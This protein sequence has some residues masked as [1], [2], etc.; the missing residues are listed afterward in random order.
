MTSEPTSRDGRAAKRLW[1]LLLAVCVVLVILDFVI[2]HHGHF[3][4][5]EIPA[6][7][8]IFGFIAFVGIVFG[9]ALFGRFVR[10]AENY[11]DPKPEGKPGDG[12]A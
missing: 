3:P 2:D 6:F 9:C 1:F 11:Y 5:E 12:H 7:F 10:R 4:V 8:A